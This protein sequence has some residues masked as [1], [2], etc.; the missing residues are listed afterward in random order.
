MKYLAL[1]LALTLSGCYSV[2][3]KQKFPEAIPELKEKCPDL[4]QIQGDKV[5]ITDL[6]KSIITNYNMYH[7]CSLKNDGWNKWYDEQ[8]KIYDTVK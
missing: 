7:E 4:K 3:I 8:R 6:L 5:A 2:P 1:I